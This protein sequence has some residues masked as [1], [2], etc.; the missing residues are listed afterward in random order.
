[1]E[2]NW[3]LALRTQY[4]ARVVV[5][6]SDGAWSGHGVDILPK[7]IP[8]Q[9]VLF[10]TGVPVLRCK[11]VLANFALFMEA[12][13]NMIERYRNVGLPVYPSGRNLTGN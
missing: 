9:K 13:T 12:K 11:I 2:S 10:R 3:L 6:F 4:I 1:L 8:A 7:T 5:A